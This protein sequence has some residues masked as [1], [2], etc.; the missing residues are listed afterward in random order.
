MVVAA[1]KTVSGGHDSVVGSQL[2][3]SSNKRLS[4]SVGFGLTQ[5]VC[6]RL[7]ADWVGYLQHVS[8]RGSLPRDHST[9]PIGLVGRKLN[10]LSLAVDQ[11]VKRCK[12]VEANKNI[13]FEIGLPKGARQS[14]GLLGGSGFFFRKT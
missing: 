12:Q 5:K 4:Q 1:G 13:L 3:S 11:T 9:G 10:G 8:G 7:V 6:W 14:A 2:E